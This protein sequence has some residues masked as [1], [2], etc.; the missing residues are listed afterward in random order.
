[1]ISPHINM[2]AVDIDN[3]QL[4]QYIVNKRVFN[5]VPCIML[6]YP[7][8]GRLEIYE[9]NDVLEF[10]NK[11]LR[12]MNKPSI[13]AFLHLPTPKANVPSMR[14][15]TQ[16]N[17]QQQ[18]INKTMLT[19]ISLDE[20]TQ[21]INNTKP[22]N[23]KSSVAVKIS[24]P[25]EEEKEIEKMTNTESS[26]NF[27]NMYTDRMSSNLNIKKGEGHEGMQ[28]SLSTIAQD[29][30]QSIDIINPID[31]DDTDNSLLI[32]PTNVSVSDLVGSNGSGMHSKELEA[33]SEKIKSTAQELLR[34]REIM[35]AQYNKKR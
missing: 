1:M 17:T 23:K 18:S 9:G 34:E 32:Q 24:D 11:I 30:N 25:F 6:S 8:E 29:N 13:Q 15:E 16:Q 28:S 26:E 2:T 20:T 31:D 3:I 19:D 21:S 22:N 5:S 33:K 27:R 14:V 7:E 10:I 35:D 4:R 12:M